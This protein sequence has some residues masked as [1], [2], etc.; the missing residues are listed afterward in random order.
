MGSCQDDENAYH[1][2]AIPLCLIPVRGKKHDVNPIQN[3]EDP[4]NQPL[5][6]YGPYHNQILSALATLLCACIIKMRI[7]ENTGAALLWKKVKTLSEK[8]K[9]F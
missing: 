9:K 8:R 5:N 4:N 2:D 6:K 3:N 7:A 1:N